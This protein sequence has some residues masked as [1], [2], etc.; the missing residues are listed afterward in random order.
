MLFNGI[1]CTTLIKK[2]KFNIISKISK[3][4]NS[5]RKMNKNIT[6]SFTMK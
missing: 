5:E 2:I 3:Y 1:I 4:Q 6:Y